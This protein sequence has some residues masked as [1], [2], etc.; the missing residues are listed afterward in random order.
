VSSSAEANPIVRVSVKDVVTFIA[1]G[2]LPA[3]M[4]GFAAAAATFW[5][6]RDPEPQYRSVAILLATR[7]AVGYGSPSIVAPPQIDPGIYRAAIIEGPVLIEALTVLLGAPVDEATLREWRRR[8]RVRVEDSLISSLIRIEVTDPSTE[9]AADMANLLA[10]TLRTWDRNRVNQ[11]LGA[12]LQ[13]L[14]RTIVQLGVQLAEA[15][16]AGD[17]QTAQLLRAAQEERLADLAATE[18]LIYSAAPIGLLEPFRRADASS[19]PVADRTV[20]NTAI[21][22]LIAV[23]ASYLIMLV[24]RAADPR[25]HSVDDAAAA[26]GAPVVALLPNKSERTSERFHAA[27]GW[28]HVRLRPH[29]EDD[30]GVVHLVTCPRDPGD[31]AGL[32]IHLAES[33]ADAGYRVLLVDADLTDTTVTRTLD[34]APNEGTPLESVLRAPGEDHRPAHAFTPGQNYFDVVPSF[35]Q[36]I[37]AVPLFDAAMR[38][39][40]EAWRTIYDVVLIDGAPVLP[41]ADA[42]AVAGLVDTVVLS[43][44]R[45]R[46][47]ADDARAAT[48]ALQEVTARP[49]LAVVVER[50]RRRAA[51]GL[52]SSNPDPAVTAT[53]DGRRTGI[54][55]PVHSRTGTARR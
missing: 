23:V 28:L 1:R 52:A 35:R 32:S 11:S 3:L 12:S 47:T 4:I 8:V 6:S 22:F 24:R 10:D 38:D 54:T 27:V 13:A 7:P 25:V 2:L 41:V 9:R 20:V 48:V 17:Q 34:L 53:R 26:T 16:A 30:V 21:A 55:Q 43:I 39:R 50:A 19:V 46:T 29:D 40:L 15:E 5:V 36:M 14:D 42:H 18:S 31:K 33:L 51:S 49:I 45:D 44:A 37:R